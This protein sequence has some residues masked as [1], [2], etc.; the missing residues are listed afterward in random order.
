MALESGWRIKPKCSNQIARQLLISAKFRD[1][2]RT[3]PH[4]FDFFLQP[5]ILKE[6][7]LSVLIRLPPDCPAPP[8][9]AAIISGSIASV[10]L[11][12]ILLLML[13]KLVIY[14]KD[15]KE[16]K[17][18]EI[19]KKNSKWTDVSLLHPRHKTQIWVHGFKLHQNR[20]THHEQI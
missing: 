1:K 17:K 19:E 15:L 12:G 20:G 3:T 4:P 14:T 11:I 2:S 5:S 10:A 6:I 18:F 7:Q 13:I 9:I 8:S 16:F